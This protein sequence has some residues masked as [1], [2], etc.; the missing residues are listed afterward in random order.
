MQYGFIHFSSEDRNMATKILQTLRESQAIDEL[1]IGR[2][3]DAYANKFFPGLSTLQRHAKY[4][5]LLPLLYRYASTLRY[6]DFRD[7]HPKI[8]ELEIQLTRQLLAGSP[9]EITGITGSDF[10]KA[11]G[12][13]NKEHYVKYD[14]TYIYASGL[15]T[16]EILRTSSVDQAIFYKSRNR[17][18]TPEQLLTRIEGGEDD[19][20]SSDTSE[21]F[22]CPKGKLDLNS[23]ISIFLTKDEASFLKDKMLNAEASKDSLLAYI[24]RHDDVEIGT[25]REFLPA[26]AISE[27]NFFTFQYQNLPAPY[28]QQVGLARAFSDFAYPLN[29]R[30][31]VIYY[32]GHEGYEELTENFKLS[33]EESKEIY[34]KDL[35]HQVFMY[36][37]L[38][39]NNRALESFCL[40]AIDLA[41]E[42]LE[43]GDYEKLDNLIINRELAV[44]GAR[45]KLRNP[46]MEFIDGYSNNL[47]RLNY[48][49]DIATTIVSEIRKGLEGW[50]PQP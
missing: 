16:Y 27:Y 3:R 47:G 17:S 1:G 30:Y 11:Y 5:V 34:D 43:S 26:G 12:A 22:I 21:F 42:G 14:P 25:A 38:Q 50:Q 39:I 32:E 9:S 40:K 48:R 2:V 49:W 37:G 7:V 35:I 18:T 41:K 31:M 28:K 45:A 46:K 23:P 19:A 4:F 13:T 36:P 29:V 33:M 10:V 8:I 6:N 44:K 15:R 20:I 24:L